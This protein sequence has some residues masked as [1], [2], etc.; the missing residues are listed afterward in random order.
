MGD[1]NDNPD[2]E[3]MRLLSEDAGLRNL[4][5]NT[6]TLNNSPGTIKHKYEWNTFDQILI[7]A[8]LAHSPHAS[9]SK[10]MKILDYA[11]LLEKD[12]N[13]TG[14]KPFRTYIGYRYNNG[15]SDHLPV[16]IKATLH[17]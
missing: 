9:I 16:W 11:F 7:S 12:E 8:N 17:A 13:Y 15:F 14:L 2:D 6:Q 3:S 1:F 10:N 5:I 4:S